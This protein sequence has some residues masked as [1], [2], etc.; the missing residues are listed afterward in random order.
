MGR[1]NIFKSHTYGYYRQSVLLKTTFTKYIVMILKLDLKT[2]TFTTDS[3]TVYAS[4]QSNNN[5]QIA[6][7]FTK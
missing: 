3:I 1:C 5:P 7:Q 4:F 2:K 6:Q